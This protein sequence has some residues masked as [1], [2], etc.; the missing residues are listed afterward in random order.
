MEFY[1]VVHTIVL[2]HKMKTHSQQHMHIFENRLD[3]GRGF[4]L[5]WITRFLLTGLSVAYTYINI[6]ACAYYMLCLLDSYV[7]MQ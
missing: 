1:W 2:A 7:H 3:L 5:I 4:A 6:C